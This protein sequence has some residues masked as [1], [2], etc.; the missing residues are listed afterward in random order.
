MPRSWPNHHPQ[1]IHNFQG[2]AFQQTPPYQG[3]MYPGMQVPSSYYPGNMQWPPN[4]DRSHIVHDQEMDS[5]KK[6]TKKNKKSQV[7]DHSEEDESTASSD[8]TYESDSD[9]N[10]KQSKKSSSTERLRNKKHGKKSSRK[11]VIRNINY[12]TSNGDGEKGSITEGS[13]SNEEEFINGNSLKHKV[14][15]AVASLEKRNRSTSRQHK[16]QHNAKHHDMLNGSSNADSNGIKGD[17]SWDAFQNLLL[18]DDDDSSHDIEKQPMKFQEEYT[19]TKKFENGRSNEFN[20]HE[21]DVTKTRVVSNDSFVVAG[22]ELDS[23]GRDHVEYFNEGNDGST[24]MQTKKITNEELLLSQRNDESGSYYVSSSARDYLPVEKNKKGILADDSFMIHA[25]PSQYQVNSQT[26]SDISLVSDIVSA[27]EFTN[28]TQE[29][30]HKKTDALI[31]R[32]PD[33]LLMVLDRDSA[34]QQNAAPWRM[35]MDNENN[36]SLYEAN[37]KISDARTERNHESN[38]EGA[39]KKNTGAKSG[40][41]SSKEAKSKT[42]NASK[43][44]SDI[45][46]RSRTLPG[47][48]STAT[49]SRSEKVN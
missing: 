34:V 46:S 36:I 30:S 7:L 41:I 3:Y 39:D 5:H 20:H 44:K 1:Y 8:S 25:R 24:F 35:E 9:D 29:G 38:H 12:I 31:S 45:M 19:M 18:I 10:S 21:A 47:S 33:D 40:K 28:G 13:L 14:E 27:A 11:V 16:K 22:R 15:E 26:A 48:R 2:H 32:E 42:P 49:K 6:K 17:N 37:K 23:K 4:G 43:T